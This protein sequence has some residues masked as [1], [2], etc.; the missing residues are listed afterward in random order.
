MITICISDIGKKQELSFKIPMRLTFPR[1]HNFTGRND[2]LLEI[3]KALLGTDVDT[4][5]QRVMVVYGLGGI[6]KSQLAAQYAYDN[7][8]MYSSVWW[9][10]ADSILSLNQ[11]FFTILQQLVSYHAQVQTSTG[12][13]PD[14]SWIATM[15]RLPAS[16]IDKEGQLVA[17]TDR[18]PIIESVKSWLTN[19]GNH[20]WLMIVDNYDDLQTVNIAD[21][22]PQ[23]TG[24]VIITSRAQQ[25][26][27]FGSSCELDVVGPEDGIEILRKSAGTQIEEFHNGLYPTFCV[28]YWAY[29]QL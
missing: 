4:T 29:D 26:R 9:V 11:D 23:S 2:E 5:R 27:R 6:G 20:A 14:Y 10:N 8:E 13:R 3:H 17:V 15:L 22:L 1:N 16:A 21:F 7:E 28:F 25:S 24:C 12:Q 19:E 18:K